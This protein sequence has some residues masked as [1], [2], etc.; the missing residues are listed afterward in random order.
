MVLY[1]N[2]IFQYIELYISIIL[3]LMYI[4]KKRD[5]PMNFY[6][7]MHNLWTQIVG[8]WGPGGVGDV[9]GLEEVMGGKGG[10]VEYFQKY[11]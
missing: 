1:F 9:S 8:W 10:P 7:Y 11:F 6:A 2:K 5:Q 3:L 4:F